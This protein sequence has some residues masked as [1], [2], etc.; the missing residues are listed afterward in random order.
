MIDFNKMLEN[1]TELQA[2]LAATKK[3]RMALMWVDKVFETTNESG[4]N[5]ML[6]MLRL[7]A[8]EKPD[9]ILRLKND[10]VIT[11]D[12]ILGDTNGTVR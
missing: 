12:E 6:S 5:L 11:L 8:R 7:L 4:E 1:D 2:E 10:M 9:V 3:S